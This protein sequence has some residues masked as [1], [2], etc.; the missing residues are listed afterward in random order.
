[1]EH[2]TNPNDP[3]HARHMARALELA[4]RGRP[5]ASPNPMVGCVVVQGDAVVGEG[6]HERPGTPHAEIHALNGAGDAAR[7]A[8]VYVTLEPCDHHGRTPP[9]S[10]ALVR[11]GVARVVVAT[12]DPDPRVDGRGLERLR[13]AGI[14]VVVGVMRREAEAQNE[15]FRVSRT[16]G[17]PFV[18]YK[19]ATT[20]DGKIATRTGQSRWI[21]DEASRERVQRWR[22]ELDAV[23]VGIETVLADDPRLTARIP[24]GRAPLKVVFDS[25]ART[26]ADA[27]LFREDDRGRPARVLV[28]VGPDAPESR[29]ATLRRAGAE[30]VEP[31][32]AE[33]RPSVTAALRALTEREVG[34]VLLEGGGTLAWSFF[35]AGVV[36]RVAW[37]IAPK[38]VG[39]TG[40]GPLAG[41]GV[42]TLDEAIR[43][44]EVRTEP[45][46]VDLL[47][48]ARIAS[49]RAPAVPAPSTAAG[50]VR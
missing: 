48:T 38:L 33:G 14:D 35:E 50:A 45:S 7:G 44:E 30:V 24:G 40:A 26:P 2:R 23:A 21:S 12:E 32:A 3:A 15:A 34:S 39:G 20:L 28:V 27:A 37:F 25:S 6:W 31:A 1:M 41:V 11:A 49:G 17:R 10:E 9:C 22:H 8:T 47:V 16:Y 36:D 29:R 4:E 13:A 42:P 18:L 5:T 19:T 46:G 43:L